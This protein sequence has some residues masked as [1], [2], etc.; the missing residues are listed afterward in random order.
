MKILFFNTGS[1]N[2]LL[3]GVQSVTHCLAH[4]FN[5]L[6]HEVYIIS[7]NRTSD[8]LDDIQIYLPDQKRNDSDANKQFLMNFIKEKHIEIVLNQTCLNPKLSVFLP[9]IKKTGVQLIS[10]FHSQPYG[11]YGIKAF[12]KICNV[13]GVDKVGNLVDVLIHFAFKLKYGRYLKRMLQYSDKLV[14]LS[15]KFINEF[16]YFSS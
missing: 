16:L 6:G 3:G 13:F 1:A 7:I 10:V 12:P 8:Y 5:S 11:M 2:P 4:Y 9:V 15:D 14:M